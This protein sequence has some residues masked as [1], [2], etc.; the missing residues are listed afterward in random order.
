MIK[1]KNATFRQ[2]QIFESIARNGS[3]TAAADELHLTQPTIS[4]QI[5]KLSSIVGMPLYDQIGRKIFLTDVGKALHNTCQ[6]VFDSLNTFEMHVSDIKGIKEGNL[7]ISGVTTTEYFAPRIIGS[8]CR[9]YPGINV[10]LEVTNRQRVLERLE[11]NLDDIY[12]VGQAPTD[13]DIYRIP[14]LANPLVVFA[15]PHHPLAKEKNIPLSALTNEHFIMREPGCGTFGSIDKL[16]KTENFSVKSSMTLGSNEA[17]KNAVI[18]GLGLSMLSIY[19]LLHEINSGEIAILDIQGF[20][21]KD[22]WYLCYPKG[23]QLSVVAQVF[24][25][26]MTFEGRELTVETLP[27]GIDFDGETLI[28]DH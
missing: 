19:A 21:V 15:P 20:P 9:K 13:P 18:G 10:T 3:F 24:A 2:L 25:E 16:A 1:M 22:E 12:I 4:M 7:T 23:K 28:I 17:I 11:Q 5:K 26:Y 6:A 14:F 8:F 27:D